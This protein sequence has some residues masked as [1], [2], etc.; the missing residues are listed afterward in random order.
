MSNRPRT[1]HRDDDDDDDRT[2]RANPHHPSHW[3][4]AKCRV[5][6]M[7][8]IKIAAGLVTVGA[9]V[10]VAMNG[11]TGEDLIRDHYCYDNFV[12]WRSL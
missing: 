1:N 5:V 10:D 11:Q 4:D 7:A 3:F 12:V 6:A 8:H 2:S 9:V